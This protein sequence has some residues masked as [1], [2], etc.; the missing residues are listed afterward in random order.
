[1]EITTSD[2]NVTVLERYA[3]V[4]WQGY[5]FESCY[6]SLDPI[7]PIY[8]V[9]VFAAIKF[10][11]GNLKNAARALNRPRDSLVRWL[12]ANP[13][14]NQIAADEEEGVLDDVEEIVKEQAKGGD[15]AQARFLLSTKGKNRGYTTKVE[16]A[17]RIELEFD[18]IVENRLT[19]DQIL[20]MAEELIA[21]R[22]LE[23]QTI[24]GKCEDAAE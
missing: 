14:F 10:Y 22:K 24:D 20:R 8:P 6:T 1:M 5:D 13:E 17:G 2:E 12:K 4:D 3:H 7:G 9:D 21:Q 16:S 18:R 11:S 23:S 19:E 15:G